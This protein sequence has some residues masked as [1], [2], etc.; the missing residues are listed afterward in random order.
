MIR[1]ALVLG[2]MFL[3]G[4]ASSYE[5]KLGRECN[6]ALDALEAAKADGGNSES[7]IPHD[8][9]YP[10][11]SN[12]EKKRSSVKKQ[13]L[14]QNRDFALRG[15]PVYIP[16]S[17]MRV[18][19]MPSKTSDYLIGPHEIYFSVPGGYSMGIENSD[20]GGSSDGVF[21]PLDVKENLGFNP[22]YS[23]KA[24]RVEPNR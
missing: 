11:L 13:M 20:S 1:V 19:I 16:D 10:K 9:N 17:P 4:C 8:G 12:K 5:C 18:T 7:A 2:V 6:N 21:G 22:D 14:D 15:Q 3:G 24:S 23:G